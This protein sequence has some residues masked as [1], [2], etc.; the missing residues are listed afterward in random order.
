MANVEVKATRLSN[1]QVEWVSLV[2][3]GANRAP[4]KIIKNRK[5]ATSMI[6]LGKSF[7]SDKTKKEA[8]AVIAA[9]LV[10]K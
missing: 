1:P 8:E 5:G 10:D 6:D 4:F 7:K 3:R 2:E 9:V